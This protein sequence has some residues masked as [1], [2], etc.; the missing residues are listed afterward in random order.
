MAYI[1]GRREQVP[2]RNSK[3]IHADLMNVLPGSA[4]YPMTY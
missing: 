4:K 2:T 3:A 1:P